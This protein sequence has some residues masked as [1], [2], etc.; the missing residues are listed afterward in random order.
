MESMEVRPIR[1]QY[2]LHTDATLTTQYCALTTQYCA[3]TTQ[4]CALTTQY[5]FALRGAINYHQQLADLNSIVW[6]IST[7]SQLV[8]L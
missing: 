4:Y 1:L 7:R 5:C 2:L 8:I 3:L 6:F